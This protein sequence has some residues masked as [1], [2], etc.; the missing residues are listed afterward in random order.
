MQVVLHIYAVNL[1]K[2]IQFIHKAF[3]FFA[4]TGGYIACPP[5][6]IPAT[7]IC[8]QALDQPHLLPVMAK[9]YMVLGPAK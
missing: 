6:W 5:A 2:I 4:A 1:T 9:D 3:Y 8:R 7:A